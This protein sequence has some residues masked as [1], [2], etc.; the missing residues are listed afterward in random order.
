MSILLIGASGRT[1]WDVAEKLHGAG[2]AFRP[3]IRNPA[4]S[5]AF[6][7]LGAEPLI[8]DLSGDFSHLFSGMHTVIYA[9]GSAESDGAEQER[10][11]DRDA[12][13]KSAEYGKQNGVAL[14][15]VISAL[16][17]YE[18]ESAPA[19]LL[20]YAQ[21]KRES[22]DY[23]I[24]SGMNHVILR[25]GPLTTDPGKGTIQIASDSNSESSRIA[26]ARQDVAE[27]VIGVLQA[28]LIDKVI[29]F[30]GGEIPIR[31]ALAHV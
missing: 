30:T 29:G 28:R 10:S 18:P 31:E 13:I 19:A 1:G 15:V 5:A 6:E 11:I 2:M 21:M 7:R 20:H 24:A 3:V 8:A 17:A 27:V 22:D 14:L 25:P 23:V 4:K 26:V 12:V 9:A 16:V